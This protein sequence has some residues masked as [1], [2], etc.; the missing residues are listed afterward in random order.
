MGGK[1]TILPP[2][3]DG[4]GCPAVAWYEKRDY[5]ILEKKLYCELLLLSSS[6]IIS[7]ICSNKCF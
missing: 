1:N 3:Q 2:A 6:V 7:N 5:F 4:K